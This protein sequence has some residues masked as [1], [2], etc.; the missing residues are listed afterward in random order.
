MVTLAQDNMGVVGNLI[1]GRGS[2]EDHNSAIAQIWLEFATENLAPWIVKVETA[3]NL[4]DGPTRD[5]LQF[6][7]RLNAVW[8]D[9]VWPEWAMNFWSVRF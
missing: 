8:V 5:D 1:S 6:M 9:P 2:A 4:A 7:R 3:C